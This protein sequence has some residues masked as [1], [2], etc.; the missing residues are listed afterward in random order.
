M[1]RHR[2][3]ERIKDH[4]VL[5]PPKD[6]FQRMRTAYELGL[7]EP[8]PDGFACRKS[9][10][11]G[12]LKTVRKRLRDLAGFAEGAYC[13]VRHAYFLGLLARG[14][15]VQHRGRWLCVAQ[16][17][18]SLALCHLPG[19][20]ACDL[21]ETPTHLPI[22][23]PTWRRSYVGAVGFARAFHVLKHGGKLYMPSPTEDME[24][25]IDLVLEMKSTTLCLTV[26]TDA[27]AETTV[28]SVLDDEGLNAEMETYLFRFARGVE[29][30]AERHG[31]PC[32]PVHLLVGMRD[33]PLSADPRKCPTV[34]RGV[35][36]LLAR[37]DLK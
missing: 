5:G 33:E 18:L 21:L 8:D 28:A 16:Q 11:D 19:P 25:K 13:A 29:A 32:V 6:L 2:D 7:A 23:R 26:K 34:A 9:R 3:F 14:P 1:S 30:F 20:A 4:A 10:D 35:R 22:D 36:S 37:F 12:V 27:L 31:G 17:E 24:D 15:A